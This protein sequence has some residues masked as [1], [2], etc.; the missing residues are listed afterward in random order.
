VQPRTLEVINRATARIME[1]LTALVADLRQ[2]PAPAERF[3]PRRAG[4]RQTGNP[5]KKERP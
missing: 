1:A 5:A 2:E 4:V 3:D